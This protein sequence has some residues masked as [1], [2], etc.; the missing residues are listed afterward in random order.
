MENS[1]MPNAKIPNRLIFIWFGNSFPYTNILAIR[2]AIK[3][4]NPQEVLL[5]HKGLSKD[6]PELQEFFKLPE[7]KLQEAGL[8][9]FDDLPDQGLSKELFQELNS[10]A[11]KANLLRLAALW[12]IGGVYLDTDT[13]STKSLADLRELEGFCGK[14]HVILPREFY[15]SKNPLKWIG[16]GV[17]MAIREVCARI[18]NGYKLFRYF[19]KYYSQS[20]NNA[21]IGS[22]PQNPL[23]KKAFQTISTLSHEEQ[24]LRFRLG[25]HLMQGVTK[26]KT[27]IDFAVLGPNYFYPQGPEI[28]AH[29]F[30]KGTRGKL[31][32]LTT[33]HT[34]VVHWY[35]SVEA[36]F[37]TEPITEEWVKNNPTTSFAEMVEKFC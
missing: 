5:L 30:K 25:T 32:L 20:V 35:N 2:S 14:E 4:N 28:S 29:W 9:W 16:V 10:P 31:D 23:I 33:E 12:K 34:Y 13:I 3:A 37:L 18:P 36:R 8:E 7:F 11:S 27:S 1:N 26:N 15:L 17:K 22:V 6:T 24:R 19:D 21:V